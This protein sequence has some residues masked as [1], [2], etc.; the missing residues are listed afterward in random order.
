MDRC[1]SPLATDY[2]KKVNLVIRNYYL[3]RKFIQLSNWFKEFL[4]LKLIEQ[5]AL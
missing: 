1:F 3:Y 5:L 2:L 4:N